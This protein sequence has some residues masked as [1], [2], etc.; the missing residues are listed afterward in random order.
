MPQ[1]YIIALQ[2]EAGKESTL[3]GGIFG[4]LWARIPTSPASRPALPAAAPGDS[5]R[6]FYPTMPSHG[7]A[8]YRSS[9]LRSSRFIAVLCLADPVSYH[10]A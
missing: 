6:L 10:Y 9:R 4:E 7:V 2:G 1:V 8:L 5:P 3:P